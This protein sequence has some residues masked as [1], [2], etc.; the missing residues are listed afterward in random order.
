M[1]IPPRV[2]LVV[3]GFGDRTQGRWERVQE[4]RHSR[5]TGTGT[6]A[7]GS[8]VNGE[9]TVDGGERG[10]KGSIGGLRGILRGGWRKYEQEGLWNLDEYEEQRRRGVEM[11]GSLRTRMNDF[12]V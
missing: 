4:I 5:G 10:T 6:V 12:G 1:T 8:D 9:S 3:S 2:A 7:A 11:F